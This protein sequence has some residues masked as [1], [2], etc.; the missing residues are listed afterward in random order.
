M[1]CSFK[2]SN[3]LLTLL[4]DFIIWISWMEL[5][6]ASFCGEKISRCYGMG[7]L[8]ISLINDIKKWWIE[9]YKINRYLFLTQECCCVAVIREFILW[10]LC[11]LQIIVLYETVLKK[12]RIIIYTLEVIIILHF[13]TIVRKSPLLIPS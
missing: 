13:L 9:F 8:M 1:C 11:Y 7:I 4:V 3:W 10:V 5:N 6:R 2:L 12:V